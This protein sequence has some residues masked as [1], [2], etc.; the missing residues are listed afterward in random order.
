M[1]VQKNTAKALCVASFEECCV[2]IGPPEEVDMLVQD[3]D[4]MEHGVDVS[5]SS[6]RLFSESEENINQC[7][8]SQGLQQ[9]TVQ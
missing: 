2:S 8:S 1:Y 3:S 4:L 7:W 5:H 6:E 9:L